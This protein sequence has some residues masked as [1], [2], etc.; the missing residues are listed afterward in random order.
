MDNIERDKYLYKKIMS[1]PKKFDIIIGNPP[2]TKYLGGSKRDRH[3]FKKFIRKS[4]GIVNDG[5]SVSM[6]VP[7]KWIS[8]GEGKT[9][10]DYL[11]LLARG[12]F[13]SIV[14]VREGVFTIRTG[15]VSHF[16]WIDKK[17]SLETDD[18][19]TP[20]IQNKY[21][22]LI[23]KIMG[24]KRYPVA[25]TVYYGLLSEKTDTHKYPVY[26]SSKKERE[27]VWSNK[28]ESGHGVLKVV[29]SN[30]LEPLRSRR[31]SE[32]TRDKGVGKNGKWWEIKNRQEGE[33]ILDFFNTLTYVFLD[34]VMRKN[35]YAYLYLPCLD[36][37]RKWT[38]Q[39]IWSH[40][41]L[42][43]DEIELV[44]EM[45]YSVFQTYSKRAEK[46]SKGKSYRR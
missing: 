14:Q 5:G 28:K 45:A 34:A 21:T 30:I 23:D 41:D 3:F 18:K 29:C 11:R 8:F 1:W 10:S 19:A 44:K 16:H 17:C 9:T 2:Y 6:V 20:S 22:L 32:I 31:F 25:G 4:E 12:T 46:D 26:L 36:F 37:S 43:N 42:S 33:N 35:R 38:D 7:H 40:C 13:V 39:D 27:C 15:K 24:D